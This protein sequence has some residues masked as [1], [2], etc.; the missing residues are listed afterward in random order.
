MI[1]IKIKLFN[2]VPNTPDLFMKVYT[3]AL[4][5]I[6]GGLTRIAHAQNGK[7]TNRVL[8][9][10]NVNSPISIA[11]ADD[12]MKRRAVTNSLTIQ[13]PDGAVNK[14]AETINY[15]DYVTAIETPLLAYLKKHP[16]IDFIVFTK[17]VPIRVRNTPGKPYGG[18]CALDSR[19]ATLGYDKSAASSVINVSDPAYNA[20][21]VGTAWANKFF[22]SQVRF[23]HKA[24]G[25]YLVTRLD[26]YTQADAMAVTTRSL[27]AE[28]NLKD[29]IKN[30]GPIL[31]DA[32]SDF[33]YPNRAAQPYTLIPTGYKPGQ[34]I[35]IIKES[36]YGEYNSDMSVA[37]NYLRSKNIP[38]LYDTT[39]NFIGGKKNL[40]GYISWGSN[41]THYQATAYNTLNFAPGAL[42]E[43]AVSTSART[44]L[45]TT[46]GQSLIEDLVAQGITGVKGYTDEPL[47]QGIA[48][49]S[50]LF[51]RYTQG[52]TLA[53]SFY[54]ASRLEGWMGIVIGD[55]ICRAYGE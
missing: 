26:G 19:V 50:I 24:F 3:V 20:T 32:C 9:V 12:Y 47:L 40:A 46:G 16:N 10:K 21:Y 38:A 54:A 43:T 4:F 28:K 49:P 25:G 55:P 23:S 52:W 6:F 27:A 14:D 2:Y 31:L 15:P 33:G 5:V 44:F 17:G 11:V 1:L 41:D 7:L 35:A 29:G 48:S 22:N 13:C 51:N 45:P 42:A 36:A 37:Y 30:E 39:V 34:S 8:V 18:V 53:E